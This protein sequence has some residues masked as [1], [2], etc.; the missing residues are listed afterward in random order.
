MKIF[1]RLRK[2]LIDRNRIMRYFLYALGE[3]VLV[4]LGILIA[5]HFNSQKELQKN[6]LKESAYLAELYKESSENLIQ[7]E[8]NK[9]AYEESLNATN[10]FLRHYNK[11]DQATSRDSSMM[12][13]PLIF[14][15]IS[16]NPSTGVV[17]SLIS[18]GAIQQIQNDSLRYLVVTWKDILK[19]FS[20]QEENSRSLWINR[21][22]PYLIKHGD[23]LNPASEKNLALFQDPVF[24]NMVSR[25]QFYVS[26]ILHALREEPIERNLREMVRLSSPE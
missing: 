21:V 22:E 12:Y 15:G 25:R 17:E 8:R 3:I 6:R 9:K 20:E 10:I 16:F 24:L 23:F 1:R 5:L 13:A 7:L 4:V 14:R 18:T 19:D 2:S 26:S 11:F